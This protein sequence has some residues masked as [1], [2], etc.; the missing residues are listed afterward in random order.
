MVCASSGNT[1][2]KLVRRDEG[3]VLARLIPLPK[4]RLGGVL[5]IR[6]ACSWAHPEFA[7]ADE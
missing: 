6:T 1:E 5:V 7:G 3:Q 4:S 2:H